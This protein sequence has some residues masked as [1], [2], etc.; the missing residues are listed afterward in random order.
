MGR[1]RANY[2]LLGSNLY[3]FFTSDNI[4]LLRQ[5]MPDSLPPIPAT[6][7]TY[8]LSAKFL[9]YSRADYMGIISEI[10]RK[11]VTLFTVAAFAQ[12]LHV[13]L[14]V[15]FDRNCLEIVR[16]CYQQALKDKCLPTLFRA[17]DYLK[18]FAFNIKQTLA[19]ND[20]KTQRLYQVLPEELSPWEGDGVGHA[21]IHNVLGCCAAKTHNPKIT[22]LGW[23]AL[24]CGYEWTDIGVL[25][26]NPQLLTFTRKNNHYLL[27]PYNTLDDSQDNNPDDS[28]YDSPDDYV[29]TQAP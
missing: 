1:R 29:L 26:V 6:G 10:A 22:T 3:N 12:R 8:E 2:S 11:D 4:Q 13:N 20:W 23:M 16:I 28:P 9:G 17:E 14:P 15:L 5:F 21:A 19:E 24:C 27:Q 25:M 7:A 18:N